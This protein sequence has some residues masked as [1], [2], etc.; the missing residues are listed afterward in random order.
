MKGIQSNYIKLGLAEYTMTTATIVQIFIL[1]Q[2]I[3]DRGAKWYITVFEK[4]NIQTTLM[5]WIRIHSRKSPCVSSYAAMYDYKRTERARSPEFIAT[6][7]QFF[8]GLR[9]PNFW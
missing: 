3:H 5:S 9:Q 2:Y 4:E 6:Y 8:I 7:K 1:K